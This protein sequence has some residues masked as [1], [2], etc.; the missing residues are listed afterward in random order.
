[1]NIA[2]FHNQP[3]GG[4]RRAL[5]GFCA[6]LVQRHRVDIYTLTSADQE[7]LRDED[8]ASS[9]TRLKYA[10]QGAIR[11]GLWLNDAMRMRDLD[12]LA[13]VNAEAAFL[14]DAR[15][16]DVVLV[17]ACRYTY[18]PSVLSYLR[19]ASVYYC[20][21]GSWH[22]SAR[23]NPPASA[24]QRARLWWHGPFEREVSRRVRRVER[25]SA[26]RATV[27]ATNSQYS[28]VRIEQDYERIAVVCPPGVDVPECSS[29]PRMGHVVSI[30]ALE[31]HKGFD[32][33][34][35]ALAT[36]PREVRPSL[37]IVANDANPVAR[38]RIE[39]LARERDVRLQI[40]ILPPQSEL[41]RELTQASCFVYGAHAEPLGLAPI[42]AMAHALPVVAVAEGGVLESVEH[43]FTGYLTSRD[44]VMFGE[45]VATLLRSPLMRDSMGQEG[46]RVASRRWAW[47][48][49]A[50]ALERVLR[51]TAGGIG[52][53][54]APEYATWQ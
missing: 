13:K 4:A 32:F 25:E 3:S 27:I 47:P 29:E 20:H 45:R 48:V 35:E 46:R 9:V 44:P 49:R 8:V 28:R 38:Q 22:R 30:G 14:I 53:P 51:T 17:D 39:S 31:A 12:A 37:H 10:T 43:G 36:I 54:S 50:A 42:E 15:G 7:M 40:R 34:V 41:E 19:T 16:Y 5:H 24:Y 18:A 1:M 2:V 11:F 23:W 33:V 26:R 52:P 21:G 6:A